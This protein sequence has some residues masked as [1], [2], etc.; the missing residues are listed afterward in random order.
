MFDSEYNIRHIH[1]IN[2]KGPQCLIR[3]IKDIHL[4]SNIC[5]LCLIRN[6]TR[7]HLI[8]KIKHIHLTMNIQHIRMIWNLKHIHVTISEKSKIYRSIRGHGGNLVHESTK[9]NSLLIFKFRKNPC[10]GCIWKVLLTNRHENKSLFL[11]KLR[12]IPCKWE[13]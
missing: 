13:V 11:F 12:K 2:N 9:N 3:N 4:I 5:T 7:T 8:R 10:S 1:L 6:G